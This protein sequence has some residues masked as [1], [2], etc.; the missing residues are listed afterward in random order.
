MI[1]MTVDRVLYFVATTVTLL[2]KIF[3]PVSTG[4]LDQVGSG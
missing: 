1:K 4:S 2:A 3:S